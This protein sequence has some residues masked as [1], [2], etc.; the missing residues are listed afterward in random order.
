MREIKTLDD[1]ERFWKSCVI[2]LK[3]DVRIL[4]DQTYEC[5]LGR[6]DAGNGPGLAF[7]VRGFRKDIAIHSVEDAHPS[8]SVG[9]S[10]FRMGEDGTWYDDA[11][12]GGWPIGSV[13]ILDQVEEAEL[14][15]KTGAH[16]WKNNS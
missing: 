1:L 8:T 7:L 13:F 4:L 15:F 12:I 11:Y 2:L 5:C 3:G 6:T 9:L 16:V 10:I 14:R